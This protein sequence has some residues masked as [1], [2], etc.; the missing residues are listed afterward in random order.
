MLLILKENTGLKRRSIEG[1]I[2]REGAPVEVKEDFPLRKY[3]LYLK[4]YEDIKKEPVI[5]E[6]LSKEEVEQIVESA[7]TVD[8]SSLKKSELIELI[9]KEFDSYK[10][11]ELKN[12]KKE[13]LLM[14][15]NGEFKNA[16]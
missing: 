13:V 9:L 2:F 16:Q 8:Y 12:L 15:L 14:I 3:S 4:K 1:V 7:E 6:K 10:E 5:E 11:S